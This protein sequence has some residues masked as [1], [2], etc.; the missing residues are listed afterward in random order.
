LG[1]EKA[2]F[3]GD[4]DIPLLVLASNKNLLTQIAGIELEEDEEAEGLFE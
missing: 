2:T 3:G 1:E 4:F